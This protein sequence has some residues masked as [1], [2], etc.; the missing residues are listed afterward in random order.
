MSPETRAFLDSVRNA[1][2]P[3]SEDEARVLSAMRAT[4]AAGALAGMGATSAS[5]L[6]EFLAAWGVPGLK[7]GPLVLCVIAAAGVADVP[8]APARVVSGLV[9]A[10][11]VRVQRSAPTENRDAPSIAA[12]PA[13]K[14]PATRPPLPA[15]SPAPATRPIP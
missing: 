9:S 1:E 4:L 11:R 7:M 3:S 13:R 14:G 6:F 8:L 5:K 2:D 10:A 15:R 12:P